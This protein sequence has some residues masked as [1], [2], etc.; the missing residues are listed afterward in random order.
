MK[1]TY[2]I[3]ALSNGVECDLTHLDE[4]AQLTGKDLKRILSN[5]IPITEIISFT[6]ST[7]DNAAR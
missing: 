3:K 4:N 6:T 1:T 5:Q 7:E 2:H